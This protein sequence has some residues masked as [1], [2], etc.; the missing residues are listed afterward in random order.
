MKQALIFVTAGAFALTSCGMFYSKVGDRPGDDPSQSGKVAITD[1]AVTKY[2]FN[3]EAPA[4]NNSL[5][6]TIK[7]DSAPKTAD[8]AFGHEFSFVSK[9]NDKKRVTGRLVFKPVSK[10]TLGAAGHA[11]MVLLKTEGI[12]ITNQACIKTPGTKDTPISMEPLDNSA[13]SGLDAV[14]NYTC[15][16]P[17]S[18]QPGKTYQIGMVNAEADGV[19]IKIS[20]DGFEKDKGY[21]KLE[22]LR[23]MQMN[24]SMT[25]FTRALKAFGSCAALP[26]SKVSFGLPKLDGT[27]AKTV[28]QGTPIPACSAAIVIECTP[29]GCRHVVNA[30]E[31]L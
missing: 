19:A 31:P 7:V 22:A 10:T 1:V 25:A 30:G 27:A 23:D 20:G 24:R 28:S 11:A 4:Y 8:L 3:N 21:L 16:L 6:Y 26:H 2:Q 13:A 5:S 18:W 12:T 17:G 9:M 15:M 14:D 29:S